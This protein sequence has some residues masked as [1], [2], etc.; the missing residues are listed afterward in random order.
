M[1]EGND[2]GGF[3]LFPG[4][5][6][7]VPPH[8]GGEVLAFVANP[9]K[10]AGA[11]P[12]VSELSVDQLAESRKSLN[13]HFDDAHRK[14][15]LNVI[16]CTQALWGTPVVFWK[17]MPFAQREDENFAGQMPFSMRET[18]GPIYNCC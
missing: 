8:E 14:T 17:A 11:G 16:G 12:P 2:W 7:H 13:R 10:L 5:A 15:T 6:V 3:P 9:L 18:C 1:K 4:R